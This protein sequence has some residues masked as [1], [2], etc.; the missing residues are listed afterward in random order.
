ME[1]SGREDEEE[2]RRVDCG[3]CKLCNLVRASQLVVRLYSARFCYLNANIT[4]WM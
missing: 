4:S 2:M 1:V 3:W